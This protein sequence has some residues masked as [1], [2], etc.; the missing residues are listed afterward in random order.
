MKK[1]VT[2]ITLFFILFSIT[3]SYTY[4]DNTQT[5][6]IIPF[7]ANQP[8]IQYK[9]HDA[10]NIWITSTNYGF[11]GNAGDWKIHGVNFPS[12]EFPGG[13]HKDYLFQGALW[14]G[15]I[16]QT[17]DTTF[18][19]LVSVG[20]DG[21]QHENEFW[22]TPADSDTIYVKSTRQSSIYYDSLAISEQ[23]FYM[24][25]TDDFFPNAS[26]AAHRPMGIRVE[27]TDY[28][29]SY[30]YNQDFVFYKFDI[31]NISTSKLYDLYFGLYIDADVGPWGPDY[32]N[33]KAQDDIT[34][35]RRW[36][37][38]TDTLWGEGYYDKD[39]N[40]ISNQP[41]TNDPNELINLAW[42]ADFDG[43]KEPDPGLPSH[44]LHKEYPVSADGATGTRILYPPPEFVSYNWW[45]S[46]AD[47]EKDW[48]PSHSENPFD[49]DGTPDGDINKYRILS[50]RYFDP[51]QVG[52]R[53]VNATLG[54]AFPSGVDSINDTRYLL[55]FGPYEIN[56]FDTLTLIISYIAGENFVEQYGMYDFTDISLNASWAYRIYDNPGFDTPL[57]GD[58]VGDGYKGEFVLYDTTG[59]W[60]DGDTVWLT[61]DG[62]PDFVGPPPPPIPNIQ[63][64]PGDQKVTILWDKLSESYKNIFVATLSGI[65]AGLDTNYFEGYRVYRSETGV[66]GEWTLLKEFDRIDYTDS[67]ELEPI[68]WNRGI[69]PDTIIGDDTFYKYVDRNVLNYTPHYYGISA[70]DK[71]WPFNEGTI[72]PVLESAVLGNKILA[73]PSPISSEEDDE[74]I[75]IPNPYRISQTQKYRDLKWEDWEGYGWNEHMRRLCFA[76]LPERCTIR[77]YSLGGD[78]VRTIEH[79]YAQSNRSYEDWNLIT[80]DV[81]GIVSGIYL[82]SVENHISGKIQ[83]G[84]FVVI[85]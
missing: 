78:L 45:L 56:P 37:D 24:A 42:V 39:G 49:V 75:V 40:S 35:F 52:E 12:C 68:A 66:P 1:K 74:V 60:Q 82:F 77:I 81:Q 6:L 10:G 64:T 59:N 20:A 26:P 11:F 48:G 80:R 8:T 63:V 3:L 31:L 28:A 47:P 41:K 5:P 67:T 58:T 72:L 27:Q 7:T 14:I 55:S 16:I 50:N 57:P 43:D 15:A 21:W 69:P 2:V 84:K 73:Y 51:D 33:E 38:N 4:I 44:P 70:F 62:I 53:G 36:R 17:S 83:V 9:F 23:D 22:A 34:G 30:T 76:N 54:Y 19:T 18:D 46:N 85:K 25:Y 71:G 61:G 29:W 79:N 65:P 13:S 32:Q